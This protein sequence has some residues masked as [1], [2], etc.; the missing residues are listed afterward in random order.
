MID[1]LALHE[2]R[3][4]LNEQGPAAMGL[5]GPPRSGK[6]WLLRQ[7]TRATA[8]SAS[9]PVFW[10]RG[11]DLPA[12]LMARDT[13]AS[14]QKQRGDLPG[15]SL[16]EAAPLQGNGDPWEALAR[17]F[18]E[19][20]RAE[21]A[22]LLVVDRADAVLADRRFAAVLREW[23][24]NVRARSRSAHLL[25]GLERRAS[26]KA[27]AEGGMAGRPES[28]ARE[29]AVGPL[30]LR[31]AAATV[32]DWGAGEIVE[33]YALVG[34]LPDFW[35]RVKSRRSPR[36]NLRRLLLEPGAPLRHLPYLLLGQAP[37]GPDRQWAV[38]SAMARGA[39]SWGDIRR[40]AGVFR[41]SSELGPY[42][43]GLREQGLVEARRSLDAPPRSRSRRY[44][45][46]R[47]LVGF[48][49][50][51]VHAHLPELDRGDSV[52]HLWHRSAEGPGGL[53]IRRHL[54]PIVEQYLR[55]HGHEQLPGRAREVG[56]LWGTGLDLPVAG[57]L[58]TGA[59]FYA[60]EGWSGLDGNALSDL[61]RQIRET[62]YGFNREGRLRLLITRRPPDHEMTRAAARSG[63]TWIFTA[64][65]LAGRM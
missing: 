39:R 61:D 9:R 12:P 35:S 51:I 3:S 37:P 17:E 45:L 62:R 47:P 41:S 23:W 7:S 18:H 25:F 27:W 63:N 54:A 56:G 49:L 53:L 13:V 52:E 38:L 36:A 48:W 14:L 28:S 32:P 42:L 24:R 16:T 60:C 19:I 43:K 21:G 15:A 40:E 6:S 57:T 55:D 34:G 46:T 5:V 20:S 64:A 50:G 1:R 26:L 31:E 22:P 33:I 30:S 29:I 2:L 8:R 10:I 11:S 65:D 58:E 4:L 44:R 59:A